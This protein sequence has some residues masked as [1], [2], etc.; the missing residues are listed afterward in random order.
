M[1][2]CFKK[3]APWYG[4]FF[5]CAL[6]IARSAV[7]RSGAACRADHIDEWAQVGRIFDGDTLRL[8]DGRVIRFIGINAPE[9]AHD[10]NPAQPLADKAKQD[11]AELIPEGSRIG[12]RFDAQ[13]YGPHHRVLAHVFDSQQ[14]NV[15]AQLLRRGDAFAIAIAPNLWQS[16]CYFQQE[17]SA[18]ME[19]LGVWSLAFYAPHDAATWHT[20]VG[21]FYRVRGRI[22]HIGHSRRSLWLDMGKF[23][24]VRIPR[25]DLSYFKG[26]SL[27]NWLGQTITLRAWGHYYR[28]KLNLTLTHPAMIERKP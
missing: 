9:L 17:Q 8:T 13:H 27:E 14:R 5:I 23:V 1:C 12:L 3:K 7:A 19:H 18:R 15:S 22:D 21:G 6:L 11:L 25:K 20:R 24:A 10:G 4:A 26:L 16:S 2:I 28:G